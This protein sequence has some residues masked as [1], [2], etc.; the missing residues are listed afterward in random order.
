MKHIIVNVKMLLKFSI[1]N[2]FIINCTFLLSSKYFGSDKAI[3]RGNTEAID[4][5]SDNAVNIINNI[6]KQNCIFRFLFNF[7]QIETMSDIVFSL[8]C[9]LFFTSIVLY[10][11]DN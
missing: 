1:F 2:K 7:N 9:N 8:A 4:K 3:R 10:F 11:L 6:D 5:T